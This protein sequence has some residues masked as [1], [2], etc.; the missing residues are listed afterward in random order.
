MA[1][2]RRRRTY[3]VTAR[4][5]GRTAKVWEISRNSTSP[6]TSVRSVRPHDSIAV[7][8]MAFRR[9]LLR[10][11]PMRRADRAAMDG[12]GTAASAGAFS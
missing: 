11:S 4:V 1:R 3:E 2:E 8:T 7:R 5:V 12:M 10:R 6:G 9:T